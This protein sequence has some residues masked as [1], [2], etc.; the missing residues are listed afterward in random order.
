MRHLI[1]MDTFKGS[2]SSKEA[3]EAVAAGILQQDPS[4]I[5]DQSPV[6]D[7]GEGTIAVYAAGGYEMRTEWT[8]DLAGRPCEVMYAQ[9]EQE[10]VVEVAQICGLAM[11]RKTDDPFL[12]HTK[13][14]G[15]LVQTLRQKGMTKIR[16]ALGGTGTTDGELGFLHEMG[17]S[18][19]DEKNHP[20]RFQTNPLVE[21]RRLTCIDALFSLEALVDVRSHYSGED[22]P[23]YLFGPQKGLR[24]NEIDCLDKRLKEMEAILKLEDIQGAGAAGGLGGAIHA[25][26]GTIVSGAQSI[27]A[28]IGFEERLQKADYVWTGEGKVDRQSQLGKI[29]GEIVRSAGIAQVPC[30]ILA[31]IVEEKISGALD[32]RSIHVDRPVTLDKEQTFARLTEQTSIW[33]KELSWEQG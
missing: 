6:A 5:I 8:V 1:L 15:H 16:V 11:R 28:Y 22:G 27:L 17:C 23:A 33:L 21:T 10:A 31:G 18:L 3:A 25:V 2:L 32:C 7:G 24:R 20:I 12:L 26:G 13:G 29:T 14:V 9:Y 19:R 30:L 4:A